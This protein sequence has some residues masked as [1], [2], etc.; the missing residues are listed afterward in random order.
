MKFLQFLSSM[1]SSSIPYPR[2]TKSKAQAVIDLDGYA[3]Y[4]TVV[5][6]SDLIL[7]SLGRSRSA[8]R[9]I[10]YD[11]EVAA[12]LDIRRNFVVSTPLKFE[13][14]NAELQ[15][16]VEQEI[17][18][19]TE[20]IMTVFFNAITYGYCVAGVEWKVNEDKSVGI[21]RFIL[22]PIDKFSVRRSGTWQGTINGV[23]MDLDPLQYMVL[24]RNHSYEMPMGEPLLSLLIR[25]VEAKKN[26][27]NFW[28]RFLERF[29]T[30][31]LVGKTPNDVKLPHP[32]IADEYIN[33]TDD[34]SSTLAN[35]QSAKTIVINE[36]QEITALET[37]SNGDQ[38]LQSDST[39]KNEIQKIILGSGGT[40]Q[41]ENNNRASGRTAEDTL[42]QKINSDLKVMLRGVQMLIDALIEVNRMWGSKQ[43]GDAKCV[44]SIQTEEE[45]NEL[46]AA[47]DKTLYDMGAKFKKEYFADTY[48][49][50]IKYLDDPLPPP[51]M[52]GLPDN[53]QD[54][55]NQDK[56]EK[57]KGKF[58]LSLADTVTG[59]QKAVDNL[60]D[61]AKDKAGQ[62][63]DPELIKLAIETA[64]NQE[65]AVK[66]LLSL[67]SYE[68]AEFTDT[69]AE[70]VYA[71]NLLGY[72]HLQETIERIG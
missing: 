6:E 68:N 12:C 16:F 70:S 26:V 19:R 30:P 72:A 56:Q 35:G 20:E 65:E 13:S 54:K 14:E 38:F 7:K 8:L 10:E 18:T 45:I 69:V 67:L 51:D 42:D 44:V 52:S 24:V 22:L 57:P 50:D 34:L 15:E 11:S 3:N 37:S 47:R 63:I 17:G 27:L 41:T 60:A 33:R 49:I 58:S 61:K 55:Q 62:P 43:F 32:T 48:A 2:L 36:D 53:P 59:E 39:L 21:N 40:V 31:T 4:D 46:L 9:A 23:T 71:A 1:V 25:P 5:A 28:L 29:G 64:D 66:N